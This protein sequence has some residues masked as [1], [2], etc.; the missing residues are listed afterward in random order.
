MNPWLWTYHGYEPGQEGVR[1]AL[2]TLGNGYQATRGSL[3]ESGA[4]GTHYPGTYL[5]GVFD[6]LR[7]SVDGQTVENESL[8][9]T[10]NWLVLR[11]TGPEGQLFDCDTSEVLDHLIELD[12][13]RALLTRR[14]RLRDD[15][16][17]VLAVTQRRFVS[18]RDPHVAAL[19]TTLV[20]ENWSGQI[21]VESAIDGRVTNSGVAR[22][23]ALGSD[24]LVG[25]D[26]R[27]PS[28]DVV[29]LEVET[30]DSKVRI[31]V[32]ARTAILDE[33]LARAVKR[34]TTTDDRYAAQDLAIEMVEG[35]EATI[36][37]VAATYTGRDVGIY[38][39]LSEAEDTVVNVVSSFPDLLERHVVSWSHA[40]ERGRIDLRDGEGHTGRV[41]NLHIF[42]LLQTASKNTTSLDVGVP[43]RGL[44]GEAYRGHIF[45]DELFIFPFLNW[46]VPELSR[47]LLQYRSRRLDRARRLAADAGYRGA[48]YPWQSASSG[49]E[50]TQVLHLNPRSG[51]WLPDASRLQHH[52]DGAVAYNVW[53]Y[54]QVTAD[55]EFMR[56][57]GSEMILEIARFWSSAATY[58]HSLDRYEIKGVMGPDEYHEGYPDAEDPGLDNNAYT[59]VLAVWCL[60]RAFDALAILPRS[61]QRQ[62]REKLGITP[63]EVDR[64]GDISRKMRL[65]FH[66]GVL[67]QFERYDEL[68]ELDWDGYRER[69][70][71]IQRLDRILEAEGASAND[72]KVAKQ[73]DTLMLFYLFSD[74]ELR[75]L[76]ERLGY[77]YPNDFLRRNLEYYEART[78]HGSTLS[79]TVSAF[80]FSRVDRERS[81]HQFREAL[82]SDVTD[83]Q[84]GTTAEGIHLG[85]MAG[86]VD[87]VQR[88]Y[89]GIETR[90]DMLR[91]DPVLP[92]ELGGLKFQ[93]RYRGHVLH[94]DFTAESITLYS[95]HD[96]GIARQSMRVCVRDDVYE[97]E[98]G[99]TLEVAVH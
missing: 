48:M 19:E 21:V 2:C 80:L 43:A 37:K 14:S 51:R 12:I 73:A 52:I 27:Q 25:V 82:R 32:A 9:N 56:F 64:W 50:E 60:I 98:P 28:D 63:E 75:E 8:V 78:S 41:L 65:C 89:T 71:N 92:A 76:L 96:G 4:D 49:R 29:S 90:E 10:P 55:I 36:D 72:F 26:S 81:W 23:A 6:R 53:Q 16:G 97:L 24:H 62:L 22:Y 54:W 57:W 95:E 11:V 34:S 67:S 99:Q 61:R 87:L 69:Y 85:A 35:V 13:R 17:R 94:L 88:C 91:L 44:H 31:A 33:Q 15:D 38:E 84:G 18:L 79:R 70:G 7:A 59:N 5:A 3:P 93:V 47:A 45:W 1:E 77:E 74:S 39:P 46:R 42:H 58:N 30:S 66:D 68:E 20:A 86:T 40:W 83:S